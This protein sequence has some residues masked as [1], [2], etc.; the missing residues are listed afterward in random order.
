M[1]GRRA[2]AHGDFGGARA[3]LL[4]MPFR[5]A[6]FSS[7]LR[8]APPEEEPCFHGSGAESVDSFLVQSSHT[9]GGTQRKKVLPG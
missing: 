7:T 5:S 9:I 2:R 8:A 3:H 4:R 6:L 1:S